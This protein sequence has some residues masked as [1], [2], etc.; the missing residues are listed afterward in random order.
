MCETSTHLGHQRAE[1]TA[2]NNDENGGNE[3][4]KCYQ[5]CHIERPN[6]K[7]SDNETIRSEG[8]GKIS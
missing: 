7:I 2:K 4:P 5:V 6:K 8:C 1:T 3:N